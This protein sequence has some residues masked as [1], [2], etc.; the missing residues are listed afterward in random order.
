MQTGDPRE[1]YGF[2]WWLMNLPNGKQIIAARGWGSQFILIDRDGGRVITV[3]GGN[4]TNN[5]FLDVLAVLAKH[6]Y[7]DAY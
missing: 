6:L 4:D 2:L 1:E 3:T 5:R 7:P